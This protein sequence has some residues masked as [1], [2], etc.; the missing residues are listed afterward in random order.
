MSD[1]DN[2]FTKYSVSVVIPFYNAENTIV[3]VLGNVYEALANSRCVSVSEVVLVD[4]ASTDNSRDLVN[5]Y[6]PK[7]VIYINKDRKYYIESANKGMFKCRYDYVLLLT[8]GLFLPIDYFDSMLPVVAQED[9]YMC[10]AK[11]MNGREQVSRRALP[12]FFSDRIEYKEVLSEGVTHS[13]M[14]HRGNLLMNREV[15]HTM[16]GYDTM[17]SAHKSSDFELA[18][19]GWSYGYKSLFVDNVQCQIVEP[20]ASSQ[21]WN[22]GQ[23]D[24]EEE[25]NEMMLHFCYQ[26]GIDL[27]KYKAR[28]VLYFLISLIAPLSIFRRTRWAYWRYLTHY[29]DVLNERK[30]KYGHVRFNLQEIE[31]YYFK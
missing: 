16:G 24:G 1:K 2:Q 26:H 27:I 23:E 18:L 10:A 5:Q 28:T 22:K 11:L 31:K 30:W 19:R 15:M 29:S 12:E 4:D 20:S 7:A 14:L 6:F 8:Q 3:Q 9:V 25:W 13:I 17:F 21:D